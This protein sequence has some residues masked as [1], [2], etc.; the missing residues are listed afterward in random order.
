MLPDPLFLTVN[1]CMSTLF[2]SSL[3]YSILWRM[4]IWLI[5]YPF[6][7]NVWER[8]ST[9]STLLHLLQMT[10]SVIAWNIGCIAFAC[11]SIF[12][13]NIACSYGFSQSLVDLITSAFFTRLIRF[14]CHSWILEMFYI[15]TLFCTLLFNHTKFFAS[16]LYSKLKK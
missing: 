11:L 3:F 2:A 13:W 12:A 4:L 5:L 14:L 1:T 6:C 16:V 10:P 9:Q 8:N 15:G 7:H